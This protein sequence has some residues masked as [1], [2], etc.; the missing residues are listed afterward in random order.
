MHVLFLADKLCCLKTSMLLQLFVRW[1]N[2]IPGDLLNTIHQSGTAL[3][4]PRRLPNPF[5]PQMRDLLFRLIKIR[6]LLPEL[7]KNAK[8]PSREFTAKGNL[9]K[10]PRSFVTWPARLTFP[11]SVLK[12]RRL[13]MKRLSKTVRSL[14]KTA[15]YPS[16]WHWS[17]IT[18]F[19]A[20]TE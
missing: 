4:F 2:F 5:L 19:K 11:R 9:V 15:N 20:N 7:F 10:M 3:F 17:W 8:F 16:A 13:L 6:T 14:G 18:K 12:T 1:R